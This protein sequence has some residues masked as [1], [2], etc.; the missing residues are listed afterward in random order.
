MTRYNE[1]RA[2]IA[3]LEKEAVDVRAAEIEAALKTVRSLIKE[4][5]LSVA[6]IGKRVF[7]GGLAKK[8][9]LARPTKYRDPATGMTWSGFGKRPHWIAAA[10]KE[11]RGAEYLIDQSPAK[12]AKPAGKAAKPVAKVAKPAA[13]K[14][15]AKKASAKSA[16]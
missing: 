15:A 11:G 1:I 4:H 9:S 10:M 2:Q 16:K 5:N 3:A 14:A 7:S 12:A 13:K 6:D 8:G